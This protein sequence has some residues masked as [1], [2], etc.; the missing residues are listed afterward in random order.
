MK[1]TAVCVGKAEPIEAKSGQSGINKRAQVGP[2]AIGPLGLAGDTIVDTDHHGGPDQAVL[3]GSD[4]DRAWWAQKLGRPLPPGYFGDNL[5]I[6][7]L[8]SAALC[9]GDRF[10]IGAV[11]LEVTSPR[12]PCASFAVRAGDLHSLRTYY[13]SARPG[14]Y[15]RVLQSGPVTT[16]DPVRLIPYAGPRIPLTLA[17]QINLKTTDDFDLLRRISQVPAHGKMRRTAQARL[18]EAETRT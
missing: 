5:E 18:S 14:A 2:V 8:D 15:A 6:E 3:I 9:I 10:E 12:I 1:L 7:G 11:T 4:L 17:L 16:G 13:A